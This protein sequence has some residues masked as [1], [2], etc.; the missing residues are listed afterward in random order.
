MSLPRSRFVW[1]SCAIAFLSAACGGAPPA[2]KCQD[3]AVKETTAEKPTSAP[4][5]EIN[6][7]APIRG[8]FAL[9][10]ATDGEQT[11]R[12]TD[13]MKSAAGAGEVVVGFTEEGTVVGAWVLTRQTHKDSPDRKLYSLCRG[14]VVVGPAWEGST[15]ILDAPVAVKGFSNAIHVDQRRV[16]AE[17]KTITSKWSASGNCGFSL[18]E[19]RYELK[20]VESDATGPVRLKMLHDKGT[21]ELARTEPIE[22]LDVKQILENVKEP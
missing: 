3:A 8:M 19:G 16:E 4:E 11:V 2:T 13:L 17:K 12:F 10:S 21:F 18:A 6:R 14:Q 20:V 5:K 15:M 1:L 22:A 9:I 7:K